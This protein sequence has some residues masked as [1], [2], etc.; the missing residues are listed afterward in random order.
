MRAKVNCAGR[1]L[2]IFNLKWVVMRYIN[3][4]NRRTEISKSPKD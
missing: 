1:L 3:Q 2:A 4:A